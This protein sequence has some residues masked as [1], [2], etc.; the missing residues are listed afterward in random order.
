MQNDWAV[1]HGEKASLN[2]KVLFPKAICK[3]LLCAKGS[4]GIKLLLV[5]APAVLQMWES[6]TRITKPVGIIGEI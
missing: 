6:P 3:F 4:W 5:G 2:G 1:G